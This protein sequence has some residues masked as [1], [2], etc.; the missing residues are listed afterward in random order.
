[1]PRGT[2]S[3]NVTNTK[4]TNFR[5]TISGPRKVLSRWE[6]KPPNSRNHPCY[7]KIGSIPWKLFFP[8]F[9]SPSPWYKTKVL[10]QR[11]LPV[12]TNGAE[13]WTLTVGLVHKFKL[14]ERGAEFRTNLFDRELEWPTSQGESIRWNGN[15]SIFRRADG[16]WSRNSLEWRP[17]LRKRSVECPGR[18]FEKSGK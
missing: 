5:S 3:I 16:W 14:A 8:L 17:R 11:V 18:R 9:E 10:N 1:M 6:F 15:G 2:Y 4:N 7:H 12:M 13:T